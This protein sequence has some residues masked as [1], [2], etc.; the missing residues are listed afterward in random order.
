MRVIAFRLL[1]FLTAA[2]TGCTGLK[3]ISADDSL[4]VGHEI[5]FVGSRERESGLSQ[6]ANEPVRPQPNPRFLWMRPALSRNNMLREKT[7]KKKF[8]RNK[9]ANPVLLSHTNP[10][11]C[12]AAIQNRIF[13]AGYFNNVVT[14][15]TVLKGQRKVAFRYTILLHTPYRFASVVFPVP[16]TDILQQ[17]HDGKE[18]SLLRRG[19]VYSLDAVK[20]ERVRIDRLLKEKGYIYFNPEFITVRVDTVTGDHQVNAEIIVKSETPPE[21]KVPYI[22]RKVFIHD[23]H[24]LEETAPDTLQVENC[25]LIS[26]HHALKFNALSRGL[27][28]RPGEVYAYSNY[29]HTIRYMNDLPVIRNSSIKFL[30]NSKSDSLD[31][32]LYLS[33]RKRYAYTAEFNAVVRSTNYFGPGVLFSYTDRNQHKGAEL[34]KVDLRG[35][36]EVQ[37]VDG[38]VNPAY[39]LG[40]KSTTDCHSFIRRYS[41]ALQKKVYPRR[42]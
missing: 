6:L 2:L 29:M 20:Q 8:W 11:Q 35:R 14:V 15:D 5:S 13:H 18:A 28:L 23:D 7:K 26:Q 31:V 36:F 38:E 40:L 4:Y 16:S 39:E 3:G 19:D 17:I 42:T 22:I 12:A 1:L 32:M 34:L 9:V 10:V 21:S 27:F 25:F 37:I 24:V 41:S 30:S 33:Q